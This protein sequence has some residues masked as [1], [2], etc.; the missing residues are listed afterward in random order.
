MSLLKFLS[1]EFA[2]VLQ[3]KNEQKELKKLILNGPET[4]VGYFLDKDNKS[5]LPKATGNSLKGNKQFSLEYIDGSLDIILSDVKITTGYDEENK[6]DY[7]TIKSLGFF[8]QKVGICLSV[9]D[10]EDMKSTKKNSFLYNSRPYNY[11]SLSMIASENR[12]NTF[13][14]TGGDELVIILHLNHNYFL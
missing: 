12:I 13:I 2:G 7:Q 3:K 14:N 5:A 11:A 9:Q 1:D 8:R 6:R 4:L 10:E